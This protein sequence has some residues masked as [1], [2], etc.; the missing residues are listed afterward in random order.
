MHRRMPSAPG[1]SPGGPAPPPSTFRPHPPTLHD[2][3]H[4]T[5][6]TS[7]HY[8]HQQ[9]QPLHLQHH[10]EQQQQQ[11]QQEQEQQQKPP[12]PDAEPTSSSS[13]SQQHH[14]LRRVA[15]FDAS[16]APSRISTVL[17]LP[18]KL[19]GSKLFTQEEIDS[20]FAS[21]APSSSSS[22]LQTPSPPM[23]GP[24][25]AP[26]PSSSS[27]VPLFQILQH[28]PYLLLLNSLNRRLRFPSDNHH[29]SSA[30]WQIIV[31]PRYSKSSAAHH[32]SPLAD[33]PRFQRM[34]IRLEIHWHRGIMLSPVSS[35]DGYDAADVYGMYMDTPSPSPNPASP[36]GRDV[37]DEE[38]GVGGNGVKKD[39][40]EE[41]LVGKTETVLQLNLL[42]SPTLE[43]GRISKDRSIV[44][45]NR[46]R[47]PNP[48]RTSSAQ[49]KPSGSLDPMMLGPQ[50]RPSGSLDAV[51]L[52]REGALEK[53]MEA[54]RALPKL[55]D[56]SVLPP[57]SISSSLL[58]RRRLL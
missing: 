9:H 23:A 21:I 32:S 50:K 24:S 57:N 36:S 33:L 45:N 31:H 37:D 30:T 27:P 47:G 38:G 19:S 40:V 52:E 44:P 56:S 42:L 4:L 2:P 43:S 28:L 49:K 55:Q 10:T 18:R 48:E 8:L 13:S 54:G 51:K 16:A 15:P 46:M 6:H 41:G 5:H 3:L 12:T 14:G 1:T 26:L 17:P 58:K 22:S 39:H 11:Q 20:I 53:A 34:S 35:H 29:P 7:S 25:A